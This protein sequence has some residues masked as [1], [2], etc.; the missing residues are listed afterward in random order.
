MQQINNILKRDGPDH[1]AVCSELRATTLALPNCL[2][3]VSASC[4][5][6]P[7]PHAVPHSVPHSMPYS[8]A[9]Q[10]PV[11][12]I[13]CP[14]ASFSASFSGPFS[15][16]FSASF[17]APSSASSSAIQCHSVPRSVP[18]LVPH[19][20]LHSVPRLTPRPDDGMEAWA[21]GSDNQRLRDAGIE[22]R[23]D[24]VHE[25]QLYSHAANID[26]PKA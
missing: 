3:A 4:L 10:C 19:S 17:S 21:A 15:A 16:P 20:V 26:F 18:H 22:V 9:I 12:A 23:L 5:S 2:S 6:A 1:L 24:G 7:L 11:L 13:Q 25:Q 14:S 8:L